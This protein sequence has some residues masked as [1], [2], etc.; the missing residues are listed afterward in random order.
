MAA[1]QVS[2]EGLTIL[3]QIPSRSIDFVLTDPPYLAH[4][5]DRTG[6]TV[7]N[8]RRDAWL[9]PAFAEISRVL[10]PGRFCVSFYGWP[11]ADKFLA[12][13]KAAGLRPVGHLV[14][15]KRYA[16][17]KRFVAY[18]HEQA[19]LLAKGNPAQPARPIRDVLP[20]HYTGNRLHPTQKP[21]PSLKPVIEAFTDQ[22]IST[23]READDWKEARELVAG[24][25]SRS[26]RAKKQIV[27]PPSSPFFHC[28]CGSCL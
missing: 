16:S 10:K 5:L 25:F 23:V 18:C 26:P 21:V 24:L 20:W 14:W 4:Y 19:Y 3:P 12:A 11:K 15:S 8:D 27:S 1:F 9:V 17:A 2:T 6:R 22:G 28:G 7:Q 13:W